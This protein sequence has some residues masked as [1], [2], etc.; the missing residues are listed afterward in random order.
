[1]ISNISVQVLESM[2]ADEAAELPAAVLI[3]LQK[4]VEREMELAKAHSKAL[5]NI[6]T[7]R[8]AERERYTRA[9]LVKPSGV[10]RFNDGDIVVVADTAKKV[11]WDRDKLTDAFRKLD[12]EI[13]DRYAKW[14]LTVE[15]RL[16]ADAPAKIK[17]A[18]EPARTVST[19]SHSYRLESKKEEAA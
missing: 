7:R 15:E 16:F 9:Q 8:Y 2:S 17:A 19:G 3:D 13:V 11:A 5:V 18:L 10:V 4:V 12:P 6:L 14:T 1:M